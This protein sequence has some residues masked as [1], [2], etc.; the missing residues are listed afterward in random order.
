MFKKEEKE[1][2][3]N[4]SVSQ[5]S[6]PYMVKEP[7]Q[8]DMSNLNWSKLSLEID[9]NFKNL[10]NAMLIVDG[11]DTVEETVSSTAQAINEKYSI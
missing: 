4:V 7:K 8:L 2:P 6:T 10:S 1:T 5:N 9:Q 3:S 11:L